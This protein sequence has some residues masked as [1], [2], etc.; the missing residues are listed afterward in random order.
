MADDEAG[1][2]PGGAGE[3]FQCPICLGPLQFPASMPCGHTTC[4][5]CL[6]RCVE[7][8]EPGRGAERCPVCATPFGLDE[9]RNVYFGRQRGADPRPRD[10]ARELRHAARRRDEEALRAAGAAGLQID[11]GGLR[12]RIGGLRAQPP[13][14]PAAPQRPPTRAERLR[15]LAAQLLLLAAVLALV[16]LQQRG[17][18]GGRAAVAYRGWL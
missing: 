18:G 15:R 16:W 5:T 1:G 13:R 14:R 17:A 4:Y 8:R 12:V 11:V 6:R 2:G 10:P 9:V 3:D 7:S